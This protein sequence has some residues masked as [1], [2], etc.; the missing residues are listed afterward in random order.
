MS[1]GAK[2]IQKAARLRR[3]KELAREDRA[4][5]KQKGNTS[6][7]RPGLIEKMRAKDAAQKKRAQASKD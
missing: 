1:R 2:A 7:A 3:S 5:K 4:S 6:G